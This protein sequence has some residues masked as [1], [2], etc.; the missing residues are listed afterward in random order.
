MSYILGQDYYKNLFISRDLSKKFSSSRLRL[1]SGPLPV[2]PG[3][4]RH[5]QVHLLHLSKMLPPRDTAP[6]AREGE[7]PRQELV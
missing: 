7:I 6:G 4:Q 2:S 5:H 3:Q 1:G